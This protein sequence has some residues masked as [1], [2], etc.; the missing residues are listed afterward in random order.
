MR[1]LPSLFPGSGPNPGTYDS[2]TYTTVFV[3]KGDA[4]PGKREATGRSRGD[5]WS[6]EE[7]EYEATDG[8]W[9]LQSTLIKWL[10]KK[11]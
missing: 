11:K 5:A 6:G 4:L 1:P 10:E 8:T 2:T 9:V 7:R 3:K